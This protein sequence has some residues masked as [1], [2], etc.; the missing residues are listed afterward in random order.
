VAVRGFANIRGWESYANLKYSGADP[1]CLSH[2]PDPD[3][4]PSRIPDATSARKEEGEKFVVLPF[5]Y[6]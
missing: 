3:F 2:I 1:V 5:S 4:Y 6:P